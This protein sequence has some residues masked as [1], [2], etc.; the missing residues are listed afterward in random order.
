MLEA[1][2]EKPGNVT[3]SHDFGDTSFEDMVIGGE[4][5]A[6]ELAAAGERRVGETILAA[7]LASRRVTPA[8]ANLG[9][10]LLL[11]PLA[12]AALGDVL[13]A[14]PSVPGPRSPVP[15]PQVSGGG[16]RPGREGAVGETLRGR[17]VGVLDGLDVADARAAY[18]AIRIAGAGGLS[19]PVAHDVR[20]EPTVSLVE[21]MAFAAWRD[22]VAAEYAL[23][24]PVTFEIAGPALRRALDDGLH[25]SDA[26]VETFL[27]VLAELPD[28]LIARKRGQALADEASA[29][30][31]DAL[32]AGGVRDPRGRAAIR[33]LDAW[34]RAE[35]NS[36]NPGTTADLITAALFVAA[37]DG[38]LG[39]L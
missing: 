35:R 25:V 27:L 19:E 8:N 9:I 39:P 6:P 7:V 2:A 15:G 11:A 18:E 3:P 38:L 29:R 10:V 32:A 28:T 21:A 1:S 13:D 26:V 12:R 37:L 4:A 20:E 16:H 36:L 5:I 30:A 24:Y 23:G 31:A 17:L 22:R 14:G 33:G 34:L